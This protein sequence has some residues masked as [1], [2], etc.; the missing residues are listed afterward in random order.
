MTSEWQNKKCNWT[1]LRVD[2]F[3]I[4]PC[5]SPYKNRP[6]NMMVILL[7]FRWKTFHVIIINF[8]LLCEIRFLSLTLRLSWWLVCTAL[9]SL[10]FA[11]F[12]WL[13]CRHEHGIISRVVPLNV[14]REMT[15]TQDSISSRDDGKKFL[16][17]FLPKKKFLV[18]V[19]LVSKEL[20]AHSK[21]LLT[22]KIIIACF[23]ISVSV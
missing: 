16:A 23:L 13:F 6:N 8:S 4:F 12:S 5:Y 2:W 17:L 1:W 22:Y 10:F 11:G 14:V 18:H 20:Y 19:I 3:L 15:L 7:L 9:F 21:I